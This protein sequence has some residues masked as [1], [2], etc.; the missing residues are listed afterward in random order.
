[1]TKN[2]FTLLELLLVAAILAI[3]F[4]AVAIT[5]DAP[6]NLKNSRDA[7]RQTD[8]ENI[9]NAI[10]LYLL[11]HAGQFPPGM[12]P[13]MSEVQLGIGTS[14]CE[15]TRDG[16]NAQVSACLNLSET[17]SH[18]LKVIPFDPNLHPNTRSTAYTVTIDSN[19]IITVRACAAEGSTPIL[20]S[21]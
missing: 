7:R 6:T 1:M 20:I 10:H 16:C 15:I 18:Y 14:G 12:K 8:V 5:L 4:T 11:D 13:G 9:L 21:R 2:G 17:L 19:R 3:L